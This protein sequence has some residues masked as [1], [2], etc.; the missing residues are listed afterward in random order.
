MRVERT[1]FRRYCGYTMPACERGRIGYPLSRGPARL[2]SNPALIK[3]DRRYKV[4]AIDGTEPR[5]CATC[6]EW[7]PARKR[8]RT[9]Y[10]CLPADKRR[11][12]LAKVITFGGS[13]ADT[14]SQVIITSETVRG[15]ALAAS[16]QIDFPNVTLTGSRTAPQYRCPV[17]Q[18]SP[19]LLRREHARAIAEGVQG[20]VCSGAV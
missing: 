9:C 17:G 5:V 13:V 2:T 14:K 12:R 15:M 6:S 11:N 10:P 1:L 4:P 16:A 3:Y 20:C 18:H 19:E 7:F 8:E